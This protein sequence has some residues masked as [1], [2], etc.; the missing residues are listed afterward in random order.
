[1]QVCFASNN[2]NK[3]KEIQAIFGDSISIV[4]LTDV[5]CTEEVPETQVTIEGNAEQK[6]A[7]VFGNYH[8]ACFADDTG[9]EV[10]ALNGEPGVFSARYA[11]P[12]RNSED[13][14][15]LLLKKLGDNA[16]RKARFKTVITYIDSQE[17][18]TFTGIIEG[19][20]TNSPRGTQGFGYDPIFIPDGSTKTFGEMSLEEKNVFSHRAKATAQLVSFLKERFR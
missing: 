11:G 16:N 1:M 12:Q 17:R 14:M 19:M 13:N 5:G 20:I 18:I 7:Y 8:I 6:A 9:L 15:A 3:H 2:K 10:D 4:S